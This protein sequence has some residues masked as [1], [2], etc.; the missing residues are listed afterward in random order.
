M[1][2]ILKASSNTFFEEISKHLFFIV[3]C[4]SFFVYKMVKILQRPKIHMAAAL[5]SRQLHVQS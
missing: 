3:I 5:H 2:H 1:W 4:N